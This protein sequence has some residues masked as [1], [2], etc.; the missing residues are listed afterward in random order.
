[1]RQ[2]LAGHTREVM[3]V[4][5]SRDGKTV[6]AGGRGYLKVFDAETEAERFAID[7]PAT[8]DLRDLLFTPGG[9][10]LVA[11]VGRGVRVYDV[12]TGQERLRLPV[13]ASSIA[14][15][16][17]GGYFAVGQEKNVGLWPAGRED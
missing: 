12:L 14:L 6:A 15:S 11:T 7:V 4:V 8:V 16:K 9:Q 17:D 2:T 3:G 10:E 5:L 1:V 13:E